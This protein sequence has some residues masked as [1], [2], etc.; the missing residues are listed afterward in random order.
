MRYV[1]LRSDIAHVTPTIVAYISQ[2]SLGTKGGM[3]RMKILSFLGR[4]AKHSRFSG[5]V[6]LVVLAAGLAQ[7]CTQV[8]AP[9]LGDGNDVGGGIVD[10]IPASG[11]METDI[12]IVTDPQGGTMI[13]ELS[14][15]FEVSEVPGTGS[16]PVVIQVNWTAPC[17]TH[18]TEAFLFDGGTQVFESMY[19]EPGGYIGMTF[20]ADISW[21]DG[22]GTHRI[23]SDTAACTLY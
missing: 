7:A 3:M 11:P 15:A 21:S 17:G 9:D 5:L 16:D 2:V 18:K 10:P 20:W 4:L 22:T 23:R 12:R 14:C 8:V 1:S 6:L 19:A 13:S